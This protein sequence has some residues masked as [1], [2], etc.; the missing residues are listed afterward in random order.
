MRRQKPSPLSPGGTTGSPEMPGRRRRGR[1]RWSAIA[2]A[3]AIA[4]LALTGCSATDGGGDSADAVADRPGCIDDFDP[5]T[6][7]FP[8][9]AEIT[10]A[11]NFSIDYHDSYQVLT[12]DEPFQGAE[13]ESYVLVKCGAPAP[14]LDGALADAPQITVPVTSVYSE[15]TTHLPMLDEIGAMDVLTGVSSGAMVSTGSAAERIASGEAVEF[16]PDG[17]VDIE[18]IVAG[19]PDVLVTAGTDDPSH[20]KLREAGVDVVANAEWLEETA[21]GR[22]EWIKFFGALTDRQAEAGKVFDGIARD[23]RDAAALVTDEEPTEILPGALSD[24]TWYMTPGGSYAGKMYVDA[25]ATWGWRDSEETGSLPLDFETVVAKAADAPLWLVNNTWQS[26]K[27]ALAE[28]ERY[29]QLA[30]MKSG[31]VWNANKATNPSG[32]NDYWES[33]V[34]HPD[35]VLRDL[36]A[37]LHPDLLPDHEFVYFQQMK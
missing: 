18:K 35:R 31:Q 37:I 9:K 14:E 13:P 15:S 33:G 32:G 1:G 4:G 3:T 19:D 8:D 29:G 23:Y 36:I 20:Q 12:V 2:A 34:L 5:G 10:E 30:A 26:K 11:S 28:D 6:D 21:L 22:A 27:D 24:G 17:A 25:G 7:Y 16:A